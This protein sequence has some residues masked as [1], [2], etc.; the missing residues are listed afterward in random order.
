[1]AEFDAILADVYTELSRESKHEKYREVLKA[2]KVAEAMHD[3]GK[4]EDL[5]K[6]L[7]TLA[8]MLS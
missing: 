5:M 3:E 4:I 7:H 8:P 6:D 2:L 1:M